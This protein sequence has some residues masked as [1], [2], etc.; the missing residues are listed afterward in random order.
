MLGFCNEP[1]PPRFP[2]LPRYWL[3]FRPMAEEFTPLGHP[4]KHQLAAA[5]PVRFVGGAVSSLTLVNLRPGP[6][7][8]VLSDSEEWRENMPWHLHPL[9][10]TLLQTFLSVHLLNADL[11]SRVPLLTYSSSTISGKSSPSYLGL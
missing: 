2:I 1:M 5:S 8:L 10:K 4:Q 9:L 6:H 3:L 7:P 11:D